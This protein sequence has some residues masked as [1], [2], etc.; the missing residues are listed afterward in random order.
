VTADG[1]ARALAIGPGSAQPEIAARGSQRQDFDD[2]LAASLV[3]EIV[4][5]D[6]QLRT[7]SRRRHA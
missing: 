2:W 4:F 6:E 5:D 7:A 1:V 3:V